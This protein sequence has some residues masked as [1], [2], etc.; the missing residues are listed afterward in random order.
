M[1]DQI[2][3]SEKECTFRPARSSED[4]HELRIEIEDWLKKACDAVWSFEK[5]EERKGA[6]HRDSGMP[7]KA[8]ITTTAR[9][10]MALAYAEWL[11]GKDEE[12]DRKGQDWRSKLTNYEAPVKNVNGAFQECVNGKG[13]NR[14]LFSNFETAHLADFVFAKKIAKTENLD[15]KD[16]PISDIRSVLKEILNMD[17]DRQNGK[18][19]VKDG[20]T[21]FDPER[22][23]SR[24]F[25]VTLH[26]LRA[27]AILDSTEDYARSPLQKDRIHG[28]AEDARRF[29]MDQCFYCQRGMR[30]MQDS[31]RLVFASLIYCMYAEEVD[32][33]VM[34]AIVE[35]I[36]SMQESNG[37]WPASHPIVREKKMGVWYIASPE[38]ALCLTWLYF[39]PALP[40]AAREIVLSILERHFRQWI[41]P[42]Y[43]QVSGGS[44]TD[45]GGKDRTFFGWQD[46]SAIGQDKVV[47][48]VSAIVCH[49]LANYM[50]VLNDHINRRVIESLGLE[51]V[52]KRYLIDET[53]AERNEKWKRTDSAG[54]WPDLLPFN[55]ASKKSSDELAKKIWNE[56]TD[57]EPNSA[58]S[59]KLAKSVLAPIYD[60][61][62]RL[63]DKF[64]AGILDGPP[65]TRKTTL[66]KTLA[67]ILEWPYVP[68][69][70]SVIFDRGFDH[71]ET[72]ASEVFRRLNYLTQC[73]IFF[74]EFEEF[75]RAR[76]EDAKNNKFSPHDRTIA[77]FTTSAMLP[78]M[79]EL[80]DEKRCLIFLAT[81][82]FD[83]LDGAIV[84][85]GRFDFKETID[86]P[87]CSRF[88]GEC[89]DFYSQKP[90]KTL[91]L[92]GVAEEGDK[93]E[94][95]KN[96]I[97][98][99]LEEDSLLCPLEKLQDILKKEG[100]AC[101]GKPEACRVPF[102]FVE[103][104]ARKVVRKSKCLEEP[105]KHSK[106]KK[107]DK[108][109]VAKECKKIAVESLSK[110]INKKLNQGSGPGSLPD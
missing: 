69:P 47:G 79:Q 88:T 109:K 85:A 33:E 54:L 80:H 92:L 81:N 63:P 101:D 82:H 93:I 22:R 49:F 41:I 26:T 18:C 86:H 72:R 5:S 28:L 68:V 24:H 59:R 11:L 15:T 40:D 78:R 56:W 94:L 91:R 98:T 43:R 19:N 55:K 61:P 23:E 73:V 10:Y 106:N 58:I 8:S 20:E 76:K 104:A 102:E 57:P 90:K 53:A 71:M 29:C 32:R 25:F 99:A 110:Q 35:A 17:E 50:A 70:A 9:S 48:W 34:L 14:K 2:F 21:Y 27:L 67:E 60:D 100:S 3:S 84:R 42:T 103:K 31:A 46:D 66:V 96:T 108:C 36:A 1:S 64:V 37:R 95:V 39:Q 30:H 107:E 12:R 44:A 77:A 65:G 75:F 38:L 105:K 51:G 45:N 87:Q 16:D 74:D 97:K 52:A 83:K 6:F 13:G 7:E 89:G 4:L 62:R